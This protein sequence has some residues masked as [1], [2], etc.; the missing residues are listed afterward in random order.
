MAKQ[1][2][3]AG[4]C[5]LGVALL[6][7]TASF[8]QDTTMPPEPAMAA[9]TSF[10][11]DVQQKLNVLGYEAGPNDGLMGPRTRKAIRAFQKDAGLPVTGEIDSELLTHLES[12]AGLG[13]AVEDPETVLRVEKKLDSL[14][15]AVGEVDG[16]VDDQLRNALTKYARFADLPVS[17]NLTMAT[18]NHVDQHM[19]RNDAESAS[20]LL[21]SVE[22]ELTQRGYR[23]GPIDGTTDQYTFR[24]IL[25]YEEDNGLPRNGQLNPIL[26]DS[27][28]IA[29]TRPVTDL[30]LRQIESRLLKQGYAPGAVDGVL[31]AQT[32]A[33]IKE[34]QTD[35]G[36]A[37][38]GQPSM[39]L[40]SDLGRSD[41]LSNSFIA[42]RGE[43]YPG[44]RT[45]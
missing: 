42:E 21:W 23:T 36:Q 15:W 4:V 27:L 10:V 19:L 8:A 13:Q 39:I 40:L 26:L 11:A 7:S 9:E 31:D 34:Y 45:D 6:S 20:K 41:T 44:R 22:T 18:V 43:L 2:I 29:D 30:D 5:A 35:A 37:P 16:K 12:S 3:R 25:D 33:A 1:H 14:G 24:A 28:E 32:E 38:T 17:D